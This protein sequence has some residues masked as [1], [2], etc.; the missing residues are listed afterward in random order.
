MNLFVL[1]PDA[2]GQI[3]PTLQHTLFKHLHSCET[4]EAADAVVVP[5]S[6][7][8]DV[9]I[10]PQ[11]L[12]LEKPV[13]VVDFLEY[14]RQWDEKETHVFGV[15]DPPLEH[16]MTDPW[17]KLDD[18]LRD[19]PPI[20]YFKRE[21]LEKDR[22]DTLVPVE[23]PCQLSVPPTQTREE[24]EARP[25]Q[26]FNNWGL[27]NHFRSEFH[28]QIFTEAGRLGITV[29]DSWEMMDYFIEHPEGERHWATIFTHHTRRRPIEEVMRYQLQA[30]VACSLPGS[31]T[32][33]FR[34][35]EAPVGCV[36]ALPHDEM[37]WG[38]PWEDKVNCL[39][40]FDYDDCPMPEQLVRYGLADDSW[41][42]SCADSLYDV[43]VAGQ[44]TIRKYRSKDYVRDYMRPLIEKALS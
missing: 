26:V 43:Y 11:L 13:I 7:I 29:A 30:K 33:C 19:H 36:M 6:Y 21:L 20:L 10:A 39:R 42:P 35:G 23:W 32:K 9:E 3:E 18:W 34:H 25:F 15:N 40:F 2:A 1:S 12:S 4:L 44:E 22:S 17:K 14:F 41:K 16:W 31:G 38:I 5:I 28:G 27:S 24:F 37:A 8:P